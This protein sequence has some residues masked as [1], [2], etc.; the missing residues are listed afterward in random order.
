MNKN[1]VAIIGFILVAIIAWQGYLL[2]K[3]A[4]PQKPKKEEPKITVE[5]EK[6]QPP[7]PDVHIATKTPRD[8]NAEEFIDQ[9]KIEEDLKKLFHDLFGNPKVQAEI[10]KNVEEIQRHFKE[11]ITQL[12]SELANLAKEFQESTQK[13]PFL[14]ELFSGLK[15]PKMLQFEDKGDYYAITLDVP[16]GK[17]ADIDIRTKKNLLIV[18]MKHTVTKETNTS[19][20]L[21]KKEVVQTSRDIILIPKDAFI[22]K[23]DTEYKNGKLYIVVPK[24][25]RIRT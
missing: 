23:L 3:Q 17:E 25:K 20:G 22:D 24:A 11:G 1:I 7:R 6:P 15:L 19:A 21:V 4:A 18:T 14:S 10:Q 5:I 8:T 2:N 16:G 12:Q 9:K 13:D